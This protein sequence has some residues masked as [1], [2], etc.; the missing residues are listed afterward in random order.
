MQYE[1]NRTEQWS[2]DVAPACLYSINVVRQ[3]YGCLILLN[4]FHC[5]ERAVDGKHLIGSND[6]L[7]C[8]NLSLQ[9]LIAAKF[10]A[11]LLPDPS[12]RPAKAFRKPHSTRIT[13]ENALNAFAQSQSQSQCHQHP[14][15]CIS[16]RIRYSLHV[17]SLPYLLISLPPPIKRH[18]LHRRRSPMNR[19]RRMP[20]PRHK[21]A[22]RLLLL[23]NH[24]LVD[25]LSAIV[26]RIHHIVLR[27]RHPVV[28]AVQLPRRDPVF[29][30]LY[31]W[32]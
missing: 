22:H 11:F 26:W 15:L 29:V 12:M 27:H 4:K 8:D 30:S 5:Y 1:Q 28:C 7:R 23:I 20:R 31:P 9:S 13:S 6:A 19:L 10:I 21:I 24:L 17:R 3:N 32:W 14:S 25:R 18:L 16:C 2:A